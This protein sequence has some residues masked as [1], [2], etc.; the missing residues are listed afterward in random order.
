M[1]SQMFTP[2]AVMRTVESSLS[3]RLR[4]G[5]A[6]M[7]AVLG[8]G[9]MTAPA[10]AEP[11][12][13]SLVSVPFTTT[14][15]SEVFDRGGAKPILT[16]DVATDEKRS[17]AIVFGAGGDV[18]SDSGPI[19]RDFA[20]NGGTVYRADAN[21][22]T[23]QP[24]PP[25]YVDGQ[26]VYDWDWTQLDAKARL[27]AESGLRWQPML[28]YSPSWAT[29]DGSPFGVPKASA[30]VHLAAY[31]RA[32]AQRYGPNGEF[33]RSNP[34][35]PALEVRSIDANNEP[36]FNQFFED[37]GSVGNARLY[38]NRY[39]EPV[40]Q[41]ILEVQPDIRI[42]LGGL[43][44]NG[45]S[46]KSRKYIS[47]DLWLNQ[48]SKRMLHEI[49][50]LGDSIAI[51]FHPYGYRSVRGIVKLR[52]Q[53]REIGL[54]QVPIAVSEM[55]LH[56]YVGTPE[57]F[58]QQIRRVVE[59]Q[60]SPMCKV[61]QTVMYGL[62]SNNSAIP[63]TGTNLEG[64]YN[65]YSPNGSITATGSALVAE[66]AH[67][68]PNR[69]LCKPNSSSEAKARSSVQLTTPKVSLWSLPLEAERTVTS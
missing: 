20:R 55:G 31:A 3:L 53:L 57:Y 10:A 25:E 37:G 68:K 9:A 7:V 59:L 14:G 22:S 69:K 36:N 51:G 19:L 32:F 4:L 47:P 62:I 6:G 45:E 60:L 16:P 13:P 43:L 34:Q 27:L 17:K 30:T 49:A 66:L 64:F 15:V 5:A 50:E 26:P 33:W 54:P 42:N 61:N 48:L 11:S 23:A 18:Y 63:D 39:F 21:W 12:E 65:L 41:A 8:T 40:S 35:L 67:L 44:Y 29:E 52:Q 24:T 58:A 2:E 46:T 28:G 1:N 56:H 38:M